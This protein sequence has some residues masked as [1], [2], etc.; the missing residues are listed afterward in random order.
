MS[1]RTVLSAAI[2]ALLVTSAFGPAYAKP[3]KKPK[4]KPI[5]KTYTV[6]EPVPYPASVSSACG[7]AMEDV[8]MDNEPFTAPAAGTF[9]AEITGF[10]GDWDLRLVDSDGEVVTE[11]DGTT[12]PNTNVPGSNKDT[13]EI[14]IKRAGKFGLQACNFAGTPQATVSYTFTFA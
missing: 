3:K 6:T 5:T 11:G 13:L 9:Y 7:D 12:T 1:P 8:S 2:A 4:P 10:E 14:K